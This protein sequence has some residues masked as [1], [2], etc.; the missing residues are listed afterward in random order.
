[1]VYK[2]PEQLFT[3]ELAGFMPLLNLLGLFN[4]GFG[5]CAYIGLS[6]MASCFCSYSKLACSL[7]RS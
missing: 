3:Q 2:N 1:V 6:I 5:I 7:Y 4:M